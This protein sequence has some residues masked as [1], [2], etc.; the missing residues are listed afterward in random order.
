M[1]GAVVATVAAAIAVEI[2]GHLRHRHLPSKPMVLLGSLERLADVHTIVF[3]DRIDDF[4]TP[5]L[6]WSASR[7]SWSASIC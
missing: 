6:S 4:V 2:T 7:W 5:G 3:P 1:L